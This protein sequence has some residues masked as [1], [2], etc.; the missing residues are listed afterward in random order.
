M[1]LKSYYKS[2]EHFKKA[3]KL[4]SDKPEYWY[5]LGINYYFLDNITETANCFE[6]VIA[7]GGLWIIED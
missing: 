5:N 2:S 4:K 3:I 7:L 1:Q 6:K